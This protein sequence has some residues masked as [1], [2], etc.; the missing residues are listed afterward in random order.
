MFLF[1]CKYFVT[2]LDYKMFHSLA[3]DVHLWCPLSVSTWIWEC[4]F[5][6]VFTNFLS[7]LV[8]PVPLLGWVLSHLFLNLS[9]IIF[10]FLN[11]PRH[12]I[13]YD[14]APCGPLIS[15]GGL[16]V[17]YR[18]GCCI[19]NLRKKS[20]LKND[21]TFPIVSTIRTCRAHDFGWGS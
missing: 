1:L 10:A 5:N 8:L 15:I 17:I 19:V 14:A 4:L 20:K 11:L 13:L 16:T 6:F 12:G 7:L 3:F 2:A 21:L 9:D 18:K